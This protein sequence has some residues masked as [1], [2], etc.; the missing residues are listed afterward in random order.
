MEVRI[1]RRSPGVERLLRPLGA[2][3]A[4]FVSACNPYSRRMPAGWNARMQKSLR[5]ALRRYPVLIGSGSWRGWSEAHLIVLADARVLQHIARR[6]RQNA[7]VTVRPRQPAKL[8]SL[9]RS[10]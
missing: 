4:G 3:Q 8:V 9:T 1:G 7:I 10:V 5:Q 6:F 2:L